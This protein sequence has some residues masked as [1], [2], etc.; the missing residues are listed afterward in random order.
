MFCRLILGAC[1]FSAALSV[2]GDARM[3]VAEMLAR[4]RIGIG[5]D[6]EKNRYVFVGAAERKVQDPAHD[7]SFMTNRNKLFALAEMEGKRQILNARK[8]QVR[9]WEGNSI[10]EGGEGGV[11]ET[12]SVFTLL[13]QAKMNGMTAI[14]SAESWDAST[15]VYQVA[16]AVSWSV[17][18]ADVGIRAAN[19]GLPTEEIHGE[20]PEWRKWAKKV[21]LANVLGGRYFTGDDGVRRFVGIGAADIEGKSGLRLKMSMR[22]A[23]SH[24]LKNLAYAVYADRVSEET[25]ES[26]LRIVESGKMSD[27]QAWETYSNMFS[28]KIAGKIVRGNEVY[29]TE[30][31]HTITGR[32]MYISVYGVAI[33]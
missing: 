10:S 17:K 14:A 23:Q 29:S 19:K 1:C 7:D 8:A 13:S 32:K 11:E 31:E 5:V 4:S 15:K 28:Q 21:R 18:L 24:A 25:A 3:A 6:R 22:L 33:K 30:V 9:A 27:S 2:F 26:A 12:R 20:S 16:V